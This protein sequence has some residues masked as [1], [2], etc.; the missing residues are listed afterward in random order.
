[1]ASLTYTY[2]YFL[3]NNLFFSIVLA[4]EAGRSETLDFFRAK[5]IGRKRDVRSPG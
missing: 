2:I 1:M 3:C 4:A 5:Y